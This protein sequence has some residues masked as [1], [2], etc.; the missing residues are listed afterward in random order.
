MHWLGLAMA[1]VVAAGGGLLFAKLKERDYLGAMSGYHDFTLL[2]DKGEFFRLNSLPETSLALLIFT[3]DGIPTASVKPFFDFSTHLDALKDKGLDVFLI[4]RTN[5][6]IVR[7]FLRASHFTS[8]FLVDAGGVVGRNL[9]VWPSIQ[10]VSTWAYVLVDRNFR[11]YW[12]R[13]DKEPIP[14]ESLMKDM[15]ELGAQLAKQAGSH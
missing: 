13:S 7:N 14:Y 4:S 10:P 3:P 11:V 2:D 9:G 12:T 8:R 1:F 6:E 5:R 15:Q